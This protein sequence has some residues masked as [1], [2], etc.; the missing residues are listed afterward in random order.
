MLKNIYPAGDACQKNKAKTRETPKCHVSY[1]CC[2]SLSVD[3]ICNLFHFICVH[4][5]QNETIFRFFTSF[6]RTSLIKSFH[7]K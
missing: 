6:V 7:I 1:V 2:S 5:I 3:H 4:Q